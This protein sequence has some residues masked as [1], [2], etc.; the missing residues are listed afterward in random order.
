[1]PI[2]LKIHNKEFQYSS[3]FKYQST[4]QY[5]ASDLLLDLSILSKIE[6]SIMESL[7]SSYFIFIE[8]KIQNL[9][10]SLF[11]LS[12]KFCLKLSHE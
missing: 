4:L 1:M 6:I 8:Y 3:K 9:L 7:S 2:I 11:S 5:L 10:S 12:P